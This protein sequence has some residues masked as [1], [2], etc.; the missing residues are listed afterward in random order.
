MKRKFLII[1]LTLLSVICCVAMFSACNVENSDSNG[2]TTNQTQQGGGNQTPGGSQT[3]T[4]SGGGSSTTPGENNPTPT[5]PE[6]THE[7]SN[8]WSS[9]D[10]THWHAATCGHTDKQDEAP[11]TYVNGVC[12][13][14]NHA[15]ENHNYGNYTAD[16]S[17]H[18]HT[19]TVCQKSES[20]AHTYV[21]GVCST[22]NHAHEEHSF[23]NWV[24]K[25]QPNCTEDGYKEHTC[26][27]CGKTEQQP[28]THSGHNYQNGVCQTC[29]DVQGYIAFKNL[30]LNDDT[31][32]GKVPANTE[33]FSFIDEILYADGVTY[34]VYTSRDC[35]PESEIPSATPELEFGDNTFY[36]LARKGN[37]RKLYT[38]TVRR[39]PVYTVNFVT[40]GSAVDSQSVEEDQNIVQPAATEKTG[41][42]FQNWTLNG[43]V[44]TF[45]YL[46]EEEIPQTSKY[47]VN[48]N[49]VF[50]AN[51][52]TVTLNAAGGDLTENEQPV[53]FD[54][55]YNFPVPTRTGYTFLGWFE[56]ENQFTN[57]EGAS[58]ENWTGTADTTLY[59]KWQANQYTV[60]LNK[61]LSA[62][63]SVSGGG[64]YAYDSQVTITASTN[65]G[66]TF[67]GW[68]K[69]TEQVSTE[70]SYQFKMGLDVTYTAKWIKVT[71][72][73]SYTDAGTITSLDK[74]YK[75][76]ESVTVTA[77]ATG[78]GYTWLG[79]YNNETELTTD[80]SYTFD[81]PDEN[82][83]YT[84]KWKV[85]DEISNFIFTSTQDTCIISG[86]KDYGVDTIIVPDYVTKIISGAFKGCS[87]LK[88]ITL[89]FV[90]E[91]KNATTSSS[92]LFGY[93]FG[94]SSYTGS[95][96]T[97][98]YYS[99]L[100]NNYVTYY[101]PNSLK[102]VTITGGKILYGAFYN[103]TSLES[104]TIPDSV[105]SIG[106]AA[107]EG[108]TSLESV[109]ITDLKSW[110]N[111]EFGNSDANPLH[112]AH[113]LYL[114]N[115]LV[116]N[117]TADL[118]Q[119]VTEIKDYAFY[120]C[121]S[122]ESIS[123]PDSV[124]SIGDDAFWS[125]TSLESVT[126]D[127]GVTSIGRYAFG[128]CTAEIKWGGNPSIKEIGDY[129]FANYKGTSITIPDSVTSIGKS[130]FYNCTSL[131]SITLPNSVTSIGMYAFG[132]CTAEIKWG[133]NP[134]I[135]EIGDY[136][137]ANYKGTSITIPDC[138]TYIGWDAFYNCTSLESIT[139]PDSVTSIGRYAFYNCTSLGTV[140][141]NAINCETAGDSY[142]PIFGGC[143]ALTNVYIGENV[144]SIP[145]YAFKNCTSLASITIPDSITSIGE[146]AFEDCK[147][148]NAV[149]I[150]DFTAWCNIK[151]GNYDAN[152][153][154]YAHNLYLNNNLVTELTAEMLQGVTKIK[155]YA[156]YGCTSLTSITIPDSVT[157]IGGSAFYDCTRLTSITL[158]NSVT[159]IGM[160]AFGNCT[161]EI[162]WGGN[163]SIK[164][165]G[166]YAFANYKGTSITIP[167][168]VTSIGER[169]FHGCTSLESVTIPD[170]VTS[171]GMFAFWE[172][173]SLTSITIPD[174][175]TSIDYKA[176]DGCTS[177]ATV[178]YGGNQAQWN[179]IS[180]GSDNT[181]LKNATRYYFSETEPDE[182]KWAES[183]NWWHYDPV[184]GEIDIWK[185]D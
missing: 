61:N 33:Y 12:S 182:A 23:D 153:L 109:Y 50:A 175:V 164:E 37:D 183:K 96:A 46:V 168:G 52:Y 110:C 31:A 80:L 157:S 154:Y 11:H 26:S 147:N 119:G 38:V 5:P 142:N 49:A 1:L 68:Y 42:T 63:G 144:G 74:T 48:L 22:C 128:N 159:S 149:Y 133:G 64:D 148:L 130:A 124:T 18:T 176:F 90:G 106:W 21:N 28:L 20:G 91:S 177:L 67:V 75:A 79:W 100:L 55:S 85:N 6:H 8:V 122:L 66:Y 47:T 112:Y 92:T 179:S 120:N 111:I 99:N 108:C 65:N 163:P 41:Y 24:D 9:D 44:V 170:G 2:G 82:V 162:K 105:T 152:P 102:T 132:N 87:N 57:A 36:I 19:C 4:P 180:I 51:G 126:I 94:T 138:V 25:K 136:A 118:L 129:A 143:T 7:F 89:P 86:L 107:F 30:Q 141:W 70:L 77:G 104:I 16:D 146:R 81:M 69:E 97:K 145:D 134:S 185:K 135:K 174:S 113:N 3:E 95:T 53:T 117:I 60:T 127:N 178:Y 160:Y 165:I 137:F 76:G 125:C 58:L 115:N 15:H 54:E 173:T 155:A 13:T 14:C 98:Q 114:N 101:I 93:V 83:T 156:F 17:N 40:D 121:A 72:A 34:D 171:I 169:A 158:P 181:D 78:L 103:C 32:Y 88:S 71:L 43:N 139:I 27:V 172:C 84:A 56:G 150:T 29:G 151:F 166:D 131:T 39:R 45:P 59:A 116:T 167:D 184:T 35:K 140:Y 161:A 10:T 73:K 62:G 123:I